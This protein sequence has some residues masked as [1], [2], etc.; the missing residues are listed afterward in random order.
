MKISQSKLILSAIAL[1]AFVIAAFSSEAI[2]NPGGH[3]DAK[4]MSAESI[5]ER[6]NGRLNKLAE[7]LEIK[8]SQQAA[9]EEFAKSIETLTEPSAKRPNDDAD[10]AT[11]SRYRADRAAE[12]AKK[13]SVI[14]DATAKLQKVLTE[15]QRKVLNQASHHFLHKHHWGH[16]NNHWQGREGHEWNPHAM[17]R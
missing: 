17:E 13:L 1:G 10:A 8:S 5:H 2:A 15:D 3:C 14:A 7:R 6:I 11:V 4:Q 16:D 12:F 9:W